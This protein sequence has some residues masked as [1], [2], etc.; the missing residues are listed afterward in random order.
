MADMNILAVDT[1][2]DACSAA[3]LTDTQLFAEYEVT[4]RAHTKLILPMVEKVL[5]DGQCELAAVDAIAFGRGPGAFT[6]VRIGTGV[7][8]G[9]ALAADCPVIPVSTLA[10]M[11]FDAHQQFRIKH[12]RVAMDARMGEVYWGEYQWQQ[13]TVQLIGEEQVIAPD[14]VSG[15]QM[16]DQW[17][18]VGNGWDV[19]ASELSARFSVKPELTHTAIYP[20]A[21][22][23]AQLAVVAWQRGDVVDAAEA[24]P[25]YL[26]NKVALTTRERAQRA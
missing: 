25:V 7:V 5:A 15:E 6:G 16:P 18:A 20:S 24:Q 21:A 1:S 8:Q 12:L 3:L 26:R 11:A 10:A 23:I 13:G 2:T 14:Q 4:P 19:F 9:L 22:A 17:A